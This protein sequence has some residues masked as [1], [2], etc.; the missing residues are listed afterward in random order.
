MAEDNK[1]DPTLWVKLIA[2]LK[3][4]LSESSTWSA[5]VVLGSYLGYVWDPTLIE[6]IC[7]IGVSLLAVIQI[8]RKDPVTAVKELTPEESKKEKE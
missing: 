4:R 1:I 2:W 7:L 8:I 5:L 3:A 6:Q